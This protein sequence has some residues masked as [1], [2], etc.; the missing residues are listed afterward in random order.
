MLLPGGETKSPDPQALFQSSAKA[1]CTERMEKPQHRAGNQQLVLLGDQHLPA[2]ACGPCRHWHWTTLR[3]NTA[4][5]WQFPMQRARN[6]AGKGQVAPRDPR[7]ALTFSLVPFAP[8]ESARS[9]PARS[10]R[11]ILLTCGHRQ[12]L[13][14][15]R[16]MPSVWANCPPLRSCAVSKVGGNTFSNHEPALEAEVGL[17]RSRAHIPTSRDS[18]HTGPEMSLHGGLGAHRVAG[19]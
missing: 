9:L 6:Q 13:W 5:K 10:T 17:A 3:Q 14:Q 7:H 11:L 2:G 8:V 4:E 16:L 1:Q 12:Q 18:G 15:A 19:T